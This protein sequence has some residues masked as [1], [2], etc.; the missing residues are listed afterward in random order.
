MFRQSALLIKDTVSKEAYEQVKTELATLNADI[1]L[2]KANIA[3][4]ELRAPF[5][6]II[7][8]REVSVGSCASPS[9]FIA[10]LTKI[11]PLKIEFHVIERYASS[12]Y[13]GMKLTF[14]VDEKLSV[15][16]ATVYATDSRVTEDTRTLAVRALYPN[17]DGL[18]FPG[19]HISVNLKLNEISNAI[20]IPTEA[21]VPELDIDKVYLYKSGKA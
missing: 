16:N 6:G 17:S 12:I 9:T 10:R 19:R 15:F 1:E 14:Q 2:V 18:L 8:L 21:I 5:D 20:A 7:G 11:S 3:Q 13:K 4:T